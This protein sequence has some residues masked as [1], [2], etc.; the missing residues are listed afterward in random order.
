MLILGLD[1]SSRVIGWALSD[2]S[3]WGHYD[4]PNDIAER[5]ALARQRVGAL[6]DI[7]RPALTA[8]ESPVG[9]FAGVL[10]QSYVRGAVLSLMPERR[11]LWVDRT[12]GQGKVA[13][14]ADGT[15]TKTEM[16]VEAARRLGVDVAGAH[17]IEKRE[18]DRNGQ[19][20]IRAARYVR[21]KTVIFTDDEA[22]AY[23]LALAG[24]AVRVEVA[25]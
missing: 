20:K 23:G 17:I 21:G 19:V 18:K 22:D 12:P 11:A 16:L 5:C 14:C 1:M 25:A 13:L 8:I 3:A 10:P 9:K 4:L 24:L 6:L 7:H 15:A 2:G